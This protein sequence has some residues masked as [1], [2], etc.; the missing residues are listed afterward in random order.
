MDRSRDGAGMGASGMSLA[1][2]KKKKKKNSG[3]LLAFLSEIKLR[4][5]IDAARAG[6]A[7]GIFNGLLSMFANSRSPS[8]LPF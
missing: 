2:G 1:Q 3:V 6:G 5:Q 8:T 7:A 4:S